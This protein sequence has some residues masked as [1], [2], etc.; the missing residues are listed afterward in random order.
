MSLVIFC[1]FLFMF[2][3]IK[4]DKFT[5]QGK[6]LAMYRTRLGLNLMDRIAASFPRLMKAVGYI[7]VVVGFSGM[8]FMFFF[9]VKETLKFVIKPGTPPPLAPVLPGISIPGVPTLS[10]WHWIIAIFIVAIVHEFSHGVLARVHKIKIQSSG[11]AFLGPILAA[12]VE[13]DEKEM[14][15]KKTMQQLSVLS[16]GP[17]SNLILGIIFLLIL[18]FLTGPLTT[19]MF[20]AGGITV[21]SYMEGYPAEAT[22]L[23]TP[24]TILKINGEDTLD[25][26]QF[27][28]ASSRIKPGDDVYLSTDKGDAKLIAAENPDNKSKGFMGV[29]GFQQ[30]KQVKDELKKYGFWPHVMLWFNIL[31]GWLFLI[32]IGVGMFNLLPLGPVDGGRIF[33]TS[34]L[35]LFKNK[36]IALRIFAVVSWICILLIFINL[37]PW[38]VKLFAWL[39]KLFF[40]IVGVI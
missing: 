11:F 29:S 3:I 14:A 23:K 36:R 2:F 17:F 1:A 6:V 24:F 25:F 27:V 19:S 39:S 26:V 4:R 40:I 30:D 7:G 5:V 38:I 37:W 28:N 35:A 10:F 8:V 12:F 15:S 22:G 16:A 9:L 34:V 32:N 18:N 20:Q 33:L 31:V 21:N 13:P